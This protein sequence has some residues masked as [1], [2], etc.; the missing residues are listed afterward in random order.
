V[1]EVRD[2]TLLFRASDF[3]GKYPA[4]AWNMKKDLFTCTAKLRTIEEELVVVWMPFLFSALGIFLALF[5]TLRRVFMNYRKQQSNK[6][7][8]KVGTAYM[9][10]EGGGGSTKLGFIDSIKSVKRD[11]DRYGATKSTLLGLSAIVLVIILILT[12]LDT[13]PK[14]NAFTNQAAEE[15]SCSIAEV[16]D[17]TGASCLEEFPTTCC[18]NLCNPG[19]LGVAPD[20]TV[21]G[22]GYYMSQSFIP[23]IFALLFGIDS[24][25]AL[26]WKKA[27]GTIRLFRAGK[28]HT[29][30]AHHG[31]SSGTRGLGKG[32]GLELWLVG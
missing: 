30:L 3:D 25:H 24:K 11:M 18:Y 16:A 9:E 28:V 27:F 15:Y 19:V 10:H 14:M 20:P 31:A 12:V 32:L 17:F 7:S 29:P 8:K 5:S 1:L 21:L 4:Y 2:P 6:S 26:V 23:L 22:I 13:F